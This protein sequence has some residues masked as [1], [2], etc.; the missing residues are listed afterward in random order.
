MEIEEKSKSKYWQRIRKNIKK[1][2]IE[3]KISKRYTYESFCNNFI[4]EENPLEIPETDKC[5]CDHDIKYNYEYKHKTNDDYII[6]GSCCI[7]KFS[8]VYKEQRKCIDCDKKI[9]KN[10]DNRCKQCREEE[11]ERLLKIEKCKCKGCGYIKKD[12]KYKYCYYCNQKN[13]FKF[14]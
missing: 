11:E 1:L 8:T 6:L 10:D 3:S 9:R 4:P 2:Y 12:D 13:K 7:K 14:Y 5:I